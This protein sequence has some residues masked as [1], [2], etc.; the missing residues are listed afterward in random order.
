MVPLNTI[1]LDVLADLGTL[2]EVFVF[3][4]PTRPGQP[5]SN[6]GKAAKKVRGLPGVEDFRAHD[7]RR[8]VQTGIT[9]LGFPRFIADRLLNHVEPGV[10][11][12]YDRHDYLREKTEAAAAWGRWLSRVVGDAQAVVQ[13]VPRAAG[14]ETPGGV[15]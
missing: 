15:T 13:M 8:T 6:F 5:L 10:G 2:D 9:R 14:D 1:A 11:S 12:R 4:S 7:L 3:P